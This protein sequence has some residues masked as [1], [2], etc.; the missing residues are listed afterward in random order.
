PLPQA[1]ESRIRNPRGH[2]QA[3]LARRP[4]APPPATGAPAR[5]G[6]GLDKTSTENN[7]KSFNPEPTA[8]VWNRRRRWPGLRNQVVPP[9]DSATA[10]TSWLRPGKPRAKAGSRPA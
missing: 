5:D 7:G 2:H 4:Q 6:D 10:L 3:A 8:T 9:V 1:D